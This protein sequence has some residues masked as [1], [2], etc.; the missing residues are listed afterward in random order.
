MYMIPDHEYEKLIH[1]LVVPENLSVEE[2]DKRYQPL[3]DFLK[4]NTPDK[5]YRFRSCKERTIKEFDQDIFGFSPAAEMNDDFDGMLY[6]DK[7]SIRATLVETLTPQMIKKTFES[8]S[9][10]AIP[11]EIKNCIPAEPL[12]RI[13]KSLPS[14]SLN[15]ISLLIKQFTNFVTKDYDNRMTFL[16]QLTQNQKIACLSPS[17]ESAAMWGY[18]A[19]DGTGFALS[20][21]LRELSFSEYCLVPVIYGDER[22]DATEY[23]TWLLQQQTLQ[24]IWTNDYMLNPLL[25]HTIPCPDEFMCTKVLIHKASNWSHEKEWRLVFYEKMGQSEK[26][27]HISKRPTAIYMGRNISAIHEKILRHIAVEKNIPAF[28]MMICE[29]NPTYSLYPQIL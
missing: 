18:Y 9:H 5:L 27:P 4:A 10:G 19:N 7:E 1:A 8:V 15:E 12:Q 20:Y 17:I 21:D 6:F 28:K 22:F 26:Y 3:M 23:A 24:R 16:S 29:N 11:A 25:H 2:K 13:I 14:L